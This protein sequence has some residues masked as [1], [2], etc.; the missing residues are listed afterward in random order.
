MEEKKLTT[1]AEPSPDFRRR[2][3]PHPALLLPSTPSRVVSATIP[4][5]KPP[6]VL[7]LS[8]GRLQSHLPCLAGVASSLAQPELLSLLRSPLLVQKEETR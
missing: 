5:G 7:P 6:N 4:A 8:S 3:H 2:E 1:H